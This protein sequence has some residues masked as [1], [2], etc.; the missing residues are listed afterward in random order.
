[1]REKTTIVVAVAF[2]SR[3]NEKKGTFHKLNYQDEQQGWEIKEATC[4]SSSQSGK[5]PKKNKPQFNSTTM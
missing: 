3:I 2:Y 4:N 5:E 1:M